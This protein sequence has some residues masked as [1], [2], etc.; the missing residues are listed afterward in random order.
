[1]AV[2]SSP[3]SETRTA[4][5]AATGCYL[6]WGLLPLAFQQMA[7]LGAGPWEILANRMVW[8][9]LAAAL[10]LLI[11]RQGAETRRLLA[12]PR[13][14]IWIVASA[15][16]IAGNWGVY[17]LGVTR[18]QTL[19]VSLGYYLTP[20]VNM[21]IGAVFLRE[22]VDRLGL[23]AM[24]LAAIGVALQTL[25]VG[26]LPWVSLGLT[27]TF[28]GYGLIRKRVAVNALPGLFVECLIL[29]GPGLVVLL[30]LQSTGQGHLFDGPVATGW[31]MFAGPLTV[32]PLALFAWAARRLTLS[33]MGFLQFLAPTMVFAIGVIQ[34]E[35][36]SAL[37]LAS[38]GFI[39]VGA[40]VFLASALTRARRTAAI[41]V[42]PAP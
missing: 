26:G 7:G 14:L 30:W 22:R 37:R 2:P 25:A 6:I 27:L 35:P 18:G 10:L 41:T 12:S 33:S 36:L 21:A 8:G 4:V 1:V 3:M 24:A 42:D 29:S 16:L 19:D 31:L 40:A 20:L 39:W 11:A 23:A 32:I 28:C 5:A 9:V 17:I 13:L 15:A 34:G 38:F